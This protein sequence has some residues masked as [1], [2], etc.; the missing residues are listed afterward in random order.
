MH[1]KFNHKAWK[2][3]MEVVH[4]YRE[5][6]LTVELVEKMNKELQKRLILEGSEPDAAHLVFERLDPAFKPQIN[7]QMNTLAD[8][9]M[10]PFTMVDDSQRA[11]PNFRGKTK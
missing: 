5:I 8:K 10:V 3:A 6:D 1:E 9:N 7:V 11:Y 2:I 4:D